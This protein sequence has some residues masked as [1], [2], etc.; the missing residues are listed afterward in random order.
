MQLMARWLAVATMVALVTG[1]NYG[2][3]AFSCDSDSQCGAGGMCEL[4][5]GHFCSFPD[6]AC[7]SGRRFGELAGGQS[8]QCVGAEIDAGI[9][10]P[11][12]A[13]P[14]APQ[15]CFGTGIVNVCL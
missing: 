9:D 4:G 10:A 5:H 15:T 6:S 3:S 13:P 8:H 11:P 14:D 7:Q 1:C 12:D 2:A